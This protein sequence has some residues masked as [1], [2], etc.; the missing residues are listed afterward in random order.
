MH[1]SSY[2]EKQESLH[3]KPKKTSHSEEDQ[4]L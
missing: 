3:D 1:N 4:Y 2:H